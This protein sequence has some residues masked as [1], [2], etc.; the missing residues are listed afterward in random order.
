MR[1]IKPLHPTGREGRFSHDPFTIDL[2][3]L[4]AVAAK[5]KGR[6]AATARAAGGGGVTRGGGRRAKEKGG[7]ASEPDH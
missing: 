4:A 6:L 7:A 3:H 1:T 2:N 5:A